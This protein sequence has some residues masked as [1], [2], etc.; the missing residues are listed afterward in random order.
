MCLQ[1]L[2]CHCSRYIFTHSVGLDE[3]QQW[4]CLLDQH[5]VRGG[6]GR[7]PEYLEPPTQRTCQLHTEWVTLGQ[8][9]N[10]QLC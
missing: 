6:S 2:L 3:D 10:P 4:R 5:A 1:E 8:N 9:Q 7:K